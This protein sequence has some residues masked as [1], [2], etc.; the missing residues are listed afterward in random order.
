MLVVF[1]TPGI[2]GDQR[3]FVEL[4]KKVIAESFCLDG[5]VYVVVYPDT[6]SA[7]KPLTPVYPID[8]RYPFRMVYERIPVSLK[9][10]SDIVF[11]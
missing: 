2:S 8:I 11:L 9:L 4:N 10:F 7:S 5:Q 1:A 3:D 6:I